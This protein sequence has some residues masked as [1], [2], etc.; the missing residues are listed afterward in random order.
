MKRYLC[1]T[2]VLF[3]V[4]LFAFCKKSNED[5]LSYQEK[6]FKGIFE[7]SMGELVF[8]AKVK[9]GEWSKESGICRDTYLEFTAPESLEGITLTRQ[10][11]K[12][13]VSL[14]K[15]SFE[16]DGETYFP[17]AEF[18]SLFELVAVP[19]S[20]SVED[21]NT[22][23]VFLDKDGEEIVLVL[24]KNGLPK[25]ISDSRRKVKVLSFETNEQ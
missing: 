25:A 1:A 21:G 13:V 20:F 10:K 2:V 12:T 9:G 3:L 19:R 7:V 15:I 23:A 5:C 22:K 14:D 11:G 4:F 24:G 8:T 16:G 17:M 6:A 18:L